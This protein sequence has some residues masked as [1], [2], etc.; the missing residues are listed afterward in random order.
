MQF[1]KGDKVAY[2]VQWLRSV[3][4]SHSD[5]AHARGI[6]TDI[7]GRIITVK[8]DTNDIPPKVLDSNLAKVGPNRRFCNID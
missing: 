5:Y 4:L 2:A 7:N 1:K 8:W 6:V 3:G